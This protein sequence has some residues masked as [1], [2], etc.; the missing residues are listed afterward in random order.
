MKEKL[1][2]IILYALSILGIVF[3]LLGALNLDILFSFIG[4]AI[5]IGAYLFK[6]EFQ[7][8]YRFWK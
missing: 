5:I 4:L 2:L 8:E 6:R 3:A 1:S 7:L